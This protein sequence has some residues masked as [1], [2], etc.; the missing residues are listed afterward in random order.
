MESKIGNYQKGK[1]LCF[2][3]EVTDFSNKQVAKVN[4]IDIKDSY[5]QQETDMGVLLIK[6]LIKWD[7]KLDETKSRNTE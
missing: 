2:D 7:K 5:S 1:K 6:Q 4:G 3:S